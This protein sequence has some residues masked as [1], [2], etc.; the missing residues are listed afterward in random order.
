M[1]GYS[2]LNKEIDEQVAQLQDAVMFGQ[3]TSY[4][5]YKF[6]CGQIRGLLA[7]KE[8]ISDLKQRMEDND[9]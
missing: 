1:D 6:L 5:E 4:E 2:L 3:L 9:D 8:I 7:A